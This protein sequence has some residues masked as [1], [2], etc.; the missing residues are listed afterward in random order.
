[1]FSD[2]ELYFSNPNS[3]K[4]NSLLLEGDESKHAVKVMRHNP[5][6]K[7]YATDGKGKIYRG[8]IQSIDEKIV[9]IDIFEKFEYPDNFQNIYFCLARTKSRDRF[10]FALEKSIELGITNFIIFQSDRTIAK[11][12]KLERWNKISLSAM[13]Q[14]LRSYL[15]NLRYVNSTDKLFNIDSD[16]VLFDQKSKLTLSDFISNNN[17]NE[18]AQGDKK[19]LFIFGPEGGFSDREEDMFSNSI[20]LRLTEN[21]LRSETAV[22]TAASIINTISG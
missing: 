3:V 12:E 21:R 11:G 1:M 4:G 8:L 15:P 18:I 7:I 6:D 10:E 9:E 17:L 22:V 2:I 20:K 5:G 16:K 14:S 13:K 19:A